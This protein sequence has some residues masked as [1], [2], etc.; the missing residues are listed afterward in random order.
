M[1]ALRTLTARRTW[2]TPVVLIVGLGAI[3][4]AVYLAGT[5]DPQGHLSGMPV[6]LVVEQQAGATDRGVA[7]DVAAALE[8]AAGGTLAI[9]RMSRS[10]LATAMH[11]DRVAGA[12]V[13]P[14]DF[15]S[16]IASLFPG[17][18]HSAV[19]VLSILTNAG[20]GG[21]SNGLLVGNLTPVLR[22][23]AD[24]LGEQLLQTAADPALPAAN[25]TLLSQPF[26]VVSLPYAPLPDNA[27]MGMSAFYY[28]L[29]LVL[30]GFIGASLVSPLV[31][32]ALGFVPSELG[33]L[34]ARR[35]YAA[36]SRRATFLGKAAI[37]ATAAPFAALALQLIAALLGVTVGAPL[38]LWLYSAAVIAAIGTSA[39]AVFS[40]FGP[41]IGSLV[42][43]LFFVALA[44]VSSGGTV[45]IA[46]TPPFFRWFSDISPYRHV[47]DGTR[48]L[49]YFDGNPAAG[50]GGAW[51]SVGVGGALGLLLGLVVTTLYGRVRAFSRHPRE[52]VVTGS[53]A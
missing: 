31:D 53:S 48:S 20:D 38:V 43:T 3:L 41:G 47:I 30:L 28:S 12:V 42:N 44:M 29:V 15:D 16:S 46:A 34:V 2:L 4:P 27:G 9:T 18:T 6:G 14:E 32:S 24:G 7:E 39:L 1:N 26:D 33:P 19:P 11:A 37:L 40:I 49:F 17:A 21:L 23:I 35:S 45:P 50:L 13:I 51:I 10:E 25:A 52:S 8:S 22:G 5:V 36:L